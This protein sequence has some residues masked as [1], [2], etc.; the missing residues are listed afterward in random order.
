MNVYPTRQPFPRARAVSIEGT[1]GLSSAALAGLRTYPLPPYVEAE[2]VMGSYL[3]RYHDSPNGAAIGIKGAFGSGKTHLMYYLMATAKEA[4]ADQRAERYEEPVQ[5]YAKA[6]SGEFFEIYRDLINWL[7]VVRLNRVHVGVLSAAGQLLAKNNTAFS[8]TDLASLRSNSHLVLDLLR[9]AL[10]SETA[11]LDSTA[12]ELKG[13]G[14]RFSDLYLSFTFLN[15]P[16]MQN[17]AFSWLRGVDISLD[18]LKRLGVSSCLTSADASRALQFISMM[19]SFAGIPLIVYIDQVERLVSSDVAQHDANRGALH[20]V[21]ESLLSNR[22]MLVVAGVSQAWDQLTPDFIQRF[23]IPTLIMPTLEVDQA[24]AVIAVWLGADL[25]NVNGYDIFPFTGEGVSE[26]VKVTRG[27]VRAVLGTCYNCFEIASPTSALIG[28][29][30][31]SQASKMLETIF[32]RSTV[33]EEIEKY[34]LGYGCLYERH[35]LLAGR[36]QDIIIP[37]KNAPT[38]VINVIEP[39]FVEDEARDAHAHVAAAQDL[40]LIFPNIEYVVV[41]VGYR[42][43]E[44]KKFMKPPLIDY[45]YTYEPERFAKDFKALIVT[46]TSASKNESNPKEA[47]DTQRFDSTIIQLQQLVA[48]RAEEQAKINTQ[49]AEIL[50]TINHP[51]DPRPLFVGREYAG[52]SRIVLYSVIT[53]G[54]IAVVGALV[55]GSAWIQSQRE[56]LSR[57]AELQ[58]RQADQTARLQTREAEDARTSG[59]VS[60]SLKYVDELYS[61]QIAGAMNNVRRFLTTTNL[62]PKAPVSDRSLFKLLIS[63]DVGSSADLLYS[64]YGRVIACIRGELCDKETICEAVLPQLASLKD[65]IAQAVPDAKSE[66]DKAPEAGN[67]PGRN[68]K[69]EADTLLNVCQSSSATVGK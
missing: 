14:S 51:V 22:N 66:I 5:I 58:F 39:V 6:K 33:I 2:R 69:T 35:T 10:I 4:S 12:S 15:D 7:G 19:Y 49:I 23:T 59:Q 13:S 32:S 11:I 47:I 38:V 44:I 18:D 42:S 17:I 25:I 24:R 26:I 8:P 53:L 37:D 27:N 30:V 67:A 52:Q 9:S 16:I 45:Y 61:D 3:S 36:Y 1:S 54:A 48:V 31:V 50:K 62:H 60:R 34:L 56:L 55:L 65:D 28:L 29:D 64:Y 57:S 63:S 21:I 43:G 46:I 20:S 68:N 40:R 41:D